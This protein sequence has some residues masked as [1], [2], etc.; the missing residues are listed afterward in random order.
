[1][2]WMRCR[3]AHCNTTATA[4]LAQGS[5]SSLVHEGLVRH[6]VAVQAATPPTLPSIAVS[7][8][9][10]VGRIG[11]ARDPLAGG[12]AAPTSPASAL[13]AA[14]YEFVVSAVNLRATL[15]S[16]L[17]VTSQ[18]STACITYDA[19]MRVDLEAGFKRS[20][21]TELLRESEVAG[22]VREVHEAAKVAWLHPGEGDA[23]L[24]AW[25]RMAAA[26]GEG[27]YGMFDGGC[28]RMSAEEMRC[29]LSLAC[30][31]RVNGYHVWCS[32][33][34][35]IVSSVCRN[36]KQLYPD[37][38]LDP[39]RDPFPAIP[40]IRIAGVS[41]CDS[42]VIPLIPT[43]A[44]TRHVAA[45][46]RTTGIQVAVSPAHLQLFRSFAA[47]VDEVLEDVSRRGRAATQEAMPGLLKHEDG[48]VRVSPAQSKRQQ[49]MHAFNELFGRL[50]V[51]AR[52]RGIL[53]A[54]RPCRRRR[55][56]SSSVTLR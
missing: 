18:L 29:A 10:L 5:L 25:Q 48:N 41:I 37:L 6:S 46:M 17:D 35:V 50:V 52:A 7:S 22:I 39:E 20:Q 36:W 15:T 45:T 8:R 51:Y 16:R 32:V 54:L 26:P 9:G 3:A 33:H 21:L 27:G 24:S 55:K 53:R 1:M 4:V 34:D 13:N 49:Q 23:L 42:N 11:L 38:I 44:G 30:R 12:T 47:A 28:G 2:A 14:D 43:A 56:A 19:G 40:A 31:T